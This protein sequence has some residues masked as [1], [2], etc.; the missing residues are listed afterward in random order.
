VIGLMLACYVL[1]VLGIA[2]AVCLT[3]RRARVLLWVGG[4]LITATGSFIL[5]VLL[6]LNAGPGDLVA[7]TWAMVFMYAVLP[8][9]AAG[10]VLLVGG[11]VRRGQARA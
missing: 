7:R 9:L 6:S 5:H 11:L 3:C 4:L 10:V 2:L 1:L 8:L